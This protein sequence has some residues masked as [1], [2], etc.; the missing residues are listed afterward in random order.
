MSDSLL[1]VPARRS[2]ALLVQTATSWSRDVLRGVADYAR[3]QGGWDCFIEPHGFWDELQLPPN[4]RGH[5]VIGRITHPGMVRALA[6]RRLPCVNVSWSRQHSTR[7]P[8]V[9]SDWRACGQMAV[10]H[11]LDRGFRTIA[12]VGAAPHM[13]YGPQLE[14]AIRTT[15][16]EGGAE[17]YSFQHSPKQSMIREHGIRADIVD[18]QRWLLELPKPV[19]VII[20]SAMIGRSVMTICANAAIEVPDDVAILCVEHDDLM[21]ALAPV[22]LSS[23]DQAGHTVG[24]KAAELLDRLIQGEPAPKKPIE[25]PPRG[26]VARRSSDATGFEDEVVTEAIRYLRDHANQPIQIHDVEKTLQVSRRVLENRFE[27]FVGRS[28]AD[29]LRRIRVER[30]AV[31]LRDTELSI[32]DIARNCGFNHPESFIRCFKRMM[33]DVPSHYRRVNRAGGASG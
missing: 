19:G 28:P 9:V 33:G 30:A 3:Q 14:E 16:K 8:N 26:V 21:S 1:G 12:Y 5:G 20:W 7:F 27:K 31:L 32:P 29:V 18:L 6:R 25:I 13:G 23:L 17:I 10:R 11:F 22:E 4:W 24:F 15:A 2:I